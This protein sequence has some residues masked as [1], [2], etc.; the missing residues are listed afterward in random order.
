[1]SYNRMKDMIYNNS[2]DDDMI[3]FSMLLSVLKNEI[4]SRFIK[5]KV[6]K[7]N[8]TAPA[9]LSSRLA[10]TPIVHSEVSEKPASLSALDMY[11]DVSLIGTEM[12][13]EDDSMYWF[14]SV[15]HI[16]FIK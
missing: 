6:V 9:K 16:K 5:T 10:K 2:D 4:E 11:R 15:D 7:V 12:E 8:E 3:D 1:M 14:K 13:D